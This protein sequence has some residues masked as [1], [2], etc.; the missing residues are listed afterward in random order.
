MPLTT[1]DHW[2][3]PLLPSTRTAQTY[4]FAATPTTSTPLSLAAIVPATCVPC[5]LP[6][7]AVRPF[8]KFAWQALDVFRSGLSRSTPVSMIHAVLPV[9]SPAPPTRVIPHG[10]V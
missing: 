3:L 6:S 1:H 4:A 2:P 7:S 10:V 8:V 5:P 9:P